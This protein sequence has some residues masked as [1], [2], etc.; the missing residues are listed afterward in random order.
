MDVGNTASFF[1]KLNFERGLISA[2][3]RCARRAIYTPSLFMKRK[4]MD[5]AHFLS[6]FSRDFLWVFKAQKF[7]NPQS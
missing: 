7:L 5:V 3:L 4:E 2:R 1:E 6:Y